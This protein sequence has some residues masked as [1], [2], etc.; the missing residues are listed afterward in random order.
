LNLKRKAPNK[1]ISSIEYLMPRATVELHFSIDHDREVSA[2]LQELHYFL[3]LACQLRPT[4]RGFG[5]LFE[6]TQF[7]FFKV[8]VHFAQP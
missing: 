7:E 2:L 8:K 1:K 4:R 6:T 3:S 5:I